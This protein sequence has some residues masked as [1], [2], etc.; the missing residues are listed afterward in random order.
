MSNHKIALIEDE[1]AIRELYR[2]HLESNGFEVEIATNG[3]SGIALIREFKPHAVLLDLML[4]KVDGFEVL[5]DL[6]KRTHSKPKIIVLTN[7][8]D[9]EVQHRVMRMGADSF[10]IKIEVTP[11]DVTDHLQLLLTEN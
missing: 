5:R 4:P 6:S 7:M 10:L 3:E 11:T 8:G 9:E 1:E 2:L